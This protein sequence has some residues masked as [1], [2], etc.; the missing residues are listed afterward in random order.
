MTGGGWR[1]LEWTG[2]EGDWRAGRRGAEWRE[3]GSRGGNWRG[4]QWRRPE[5]KSN[6]NLVTACVGHSTVEAGRRASATR[7]G[8]TWHRRL[9]ACVGHGAVDA[10]WRASAMGCALKSA[11][12]TWHAAR[13]TIHKTTHEAE[14]THTTNTTRLTHT[15]RYTPAT[16]TIDKT[17]TAQTTHTTYET[18]VTHKTHATH[19]IRKTA[20]RRPRCSHLDATD[21]LPLAQQLA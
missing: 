19:A 10:G 4:F 8:L 12:A 9:A 1:C 7:R 11:Q 3:E 21:T 15:T 20:H 5:G 2:G 17:T 13:H 18:R 14:T 6:H 16:H